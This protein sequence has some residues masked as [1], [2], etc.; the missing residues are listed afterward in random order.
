MS[1]LRLKE[2]DK[3]FN[4]GSIAVIG[5]S[6]KKGSVGYT[7]LNNL[8]GSGYEGVVYPVS[9]T[10]T[11]VQGIHSYTSIDQVPR[12]IDLAIIAVPAK[13]TPEI[14]RECGESGVGA[15]VIVSA[16]FKEIGDEGKYLEDELLDIA[17]DYGIRFIGPNCLGVIRPKIHLNASFAQL[18]PDDGNVAFISQSGALC[19]AVLD[20]CY[21]R[22][23]GF[24]SFVSVGSMA[25][26][27]FGDLIDYFGMDPDTNA[28]ILYIEALKDVRGFMSAARHFAR[29]KPIVVVKSGRLERSAKAATS[30]TGAMA[31]DDDLYDAAFK[32]AG[33]IRVTEVE[34]LFNCAEALNS[35]TKPGGNRL[36]IVTNAGGPGVMAA[37]A[38]L[39][40][41]G[42][43]AELSKETIE[44]LDV[45]L[46]S[47][48]SHGNPVDIVGDASPERYRDATSIILKDSN[49]DGVLLILTPQSMSD[50][51]QT[52]R[53]IAE[54]NLKNIEKPVLASWMGEAS[55]ES[56]RTILESGG[57]PSFET[58]ENAIATYLHMYQYTKNIA[59]LYETPED[60]LTGFHPEKDEIKAI[61]KKVAKEER[62]LLT[63]HESLQVLG[64]Y[65]IPTVR[66]DVAHDPGEAVK[67]AEDIG[68]PV[69][70]KIISQEISHKTEI[71]CVKIDIR[72]S[73]DAKDAYEEIN[74][75]A[76]EHNPDAEIDGTA[77]QPMIAGRGYEVIIGSK[78]DAAFGPAVIFGTGGTMVEYI[79]DRS[80]GFPPLNQALAHRLI[81]DTKI[82]KILNNG[83]RGRPPANIRLIEEA[84]VKISFFLI[85]FPEIIEMD[86]NPI[87]VDEA[88]LLALDARILID[89]AKV[90]I[91]D[92]PGSDLIISR[93]P[94]KYNQEWV[95]LAGDKIFFRVIRPEDEP[96]WVDMMNSFSKETIRYRFFGPLGGLNHN[97]VV[98]Y[99]HIDYD[100]EVALA[101]LVKEDEGYK[102]VGVGRVVIIS[103]EDEG[104]FAVVVRDEWQGEGIG[105]KLIDLMIGIARDFRL[106]KIIGDVLG[107]NLKLLKIAEEKGFKVKR[108]ED[109]GLRRIVL[110]L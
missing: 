13:T 81:E 41:G 64:A 21:D 3:I 23:I 12:R 66:T 42:V 55:V 67:I 63:V 48:W 30:H 47:F 38:L 72:K 43:L 24:S 59:S 29:T 44:K 83:F 11:S 97:M 58:P 45:Y 10:A 51:E 76:K 100:R 74:R 80:I 60:I 94:T 104:E 37:D 2:L 98:R 16:G 17:S 20:W 88:S 110:K 75:N 28:I 87:Y 108:H 49:V 78:R 106:R 32:R 84:L 34:E 40:T 26:V 4:P 101:A 54:L 18:V 103:D 5:A 15:A 85:D 109:P 35:Q 39:S 82:S 1:A 7:L 22:G 65:G 89:P 53:Y 71:G 105:S 91:S 77:I 31:G 36:A 102:M 95:T 79:K 68:Y 52:A 8:I 27:T 50:P 19:T 14:M 46:P 57:I 107:D 9:K 73:E 33:I 6:N 86:L 62:G 25:D 99:C 90:Y 92:Q 61:F 69:A 56:G 96:L 93:C 70:M